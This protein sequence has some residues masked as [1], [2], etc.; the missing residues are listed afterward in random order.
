MLALVGPDD[1]S[2][3]VPARRRRQWRRARGFADARGTARIEAATDPD[4]FMDALARLHGARWTS[5]GEDGLLVQDSV[6]PFQRRALRG[7]MAAGV[8]RCHLLTIDG[9]P[10]GAYYGF[11]ARERAYAYLGGFD[12]DYAEASPGAILLGHAIVEAMRSGATEF[13]FLRGQEDYKYTWG[14]QD[15][16]NQRRTWRRVP[17]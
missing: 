5:R 1:L 14:A 9:R 16:W 7:L 10:V 12:P 2:G 11:L 17:T 4:A 15:R 3:C 8:A 13:H 6:E